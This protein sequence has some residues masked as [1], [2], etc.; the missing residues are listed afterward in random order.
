[1]GDRDRKEK[2]QGGLY[3]YLCLA[4]LDSRFRGNDESLL[5]LAP[6]PERVILLL[7]LLHP[8]FHADVVSRGPPVLANCDHQRKNP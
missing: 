6:P 7:A 4:M 5:P 8:Q 3:L 1:M 2:G